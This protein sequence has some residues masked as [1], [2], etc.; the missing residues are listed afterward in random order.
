MILYKWGTNIHRIRE[1]RLRL[2][3][4]R[5][6]YNITSAQPSSALIS[7]GL[8]KSKRHHLIILTSPSS[9]M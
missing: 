5:P 7:S 6:R 3:Q 9:S 4:L 8:V 2:R 1:L